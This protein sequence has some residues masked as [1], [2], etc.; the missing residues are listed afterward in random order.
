MVILSIKEIIDIII[1]TAIIGFIFMDFFKIERK[2]NLIAMMQ[3]KFFN[4]EGF[5]NAII[6]IAPAIIFHEFGHKFVA[7]SFGLS[8]SFNAAYIWLF[9]A[10]ILRF[11]IPGFIFLVPAYVSFSASATHLQSVFIAFAGPGVN[12]LIFGLVSLYFVYAKRKKLQIKRKTMFMLILTK[13]VN[14][15]LFI[16]NMLPIPGFDGFH[17]FS[18]LIKIIF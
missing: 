12:L 7:M 2:N 11:I 1:M 18:N 16:F 9:I 6:I 8:A 10:L 15:F 3:K 17:F 14:L 13:K 4:K 5:L